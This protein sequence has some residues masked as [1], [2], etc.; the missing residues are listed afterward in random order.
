V[1]GLA[2]LGLA[3]VLTGAVLTNVVVLGESPAVPL[4]LLAL[5]AS[6]CWARR[7]GIR[8]TVDRRHAP[9]DVA[10]T[11]RSSGPG[12]RAGVK[13]ASVDVPPQSTRVGAA[14]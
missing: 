2:A 10:L 7:D 12:H 8:T 13:S 14:D 5:A 9:A 3:G 11:T 1:W 6:V 4:T